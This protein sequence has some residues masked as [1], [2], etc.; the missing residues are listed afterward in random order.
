MSL[1]E[2]SNPFNKYPILPRSYKSIQ[3]RQKSQDVIVIK[4]L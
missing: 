2:Y 1:F 3:T 4:V